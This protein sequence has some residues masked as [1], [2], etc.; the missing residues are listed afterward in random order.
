MDR[1]GPAAAGS[2]RGERAAHRVH[3]VCG[4]ARVHFATDAS[5]R[6]ADLEWY[7][8]WGRAEIVLHG[9][10]DRSIRKPADLAA[11]ASYRWLRRC[12]SSFR[13][14]YTREIGPA[15]GNEE[16]CGRLQGLSANCRVCTH[17]LAVSGATKPE[18]VAHPEVTRALE[19][20][21]I[22]ALVNCLTVTE[23]DRGADTTRRNVEFLAQFEEVLASHSHEQLSTAALAGAM[24]VPE[25]TLRRRCATSLGMS[26]G[27]YAR[28]RRLNFVRTAL[29]HA[30][31]ETVSVGE[32]ARRHGFS[33]LGRFSVAYRTLFGEVAVAHPA[34]RLFTKAGAER[35]RIVQTILW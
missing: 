4:G 20:D 6:S 11:G 26:P 9:R 28:L 18:L 12:S 16:S 8:S 34:I 30:D 15:I 17:A 21:F 35:N 22:Q 23:P 24:G 1:H 25:R 5:R 33:E 19:Q 29:R 7:S 10:G 32:I 31:P 3:R 27:R 13:D 14:V 2:L